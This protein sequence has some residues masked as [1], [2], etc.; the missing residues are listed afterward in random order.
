MPQDS[1]SFPN[2]L[3]FTLLYLPNSVSHDQIFAINHLLDLVKQ[4]RSLFSY[5]KPKEIFNRAMISTSRI[6][7]VFLCMLLISCQRK[8][9]DQGIAF[10]KSETIVIGN[11][12]L[13]P[14]LI[15]ELL[16]SVEYIKLETSS[17][18]LIKDI[19]DVIFAKN[20]FYIQNGRDNLLCFDNSGKFLFQVGGNGRGPG[21]Y[22]SCHQVVIKEEQNRIWIVDKQLMKILQYDLEG[23]FIESLPYDFFY[24]LYFPLNYDKHCFYL[25]TTS[26]SSRSF[27]SHMIIRTDDNFVLE[28]AYLPIDPQIIQINYSNSRIGYYYNG[29]L[30]I[31]PDFQNVIYGIGEDSIWQRYILDFGNEFITEAEVLKIA[32]K[33]DLDEMFIGLRESGK[34]Y[35]VAYLLE[36]DNYLYF[37]YSKNGD[38]VTNFYSKTSKLLYS[39]M[40]FEDDLGSGI[41]YDLPLGLAGDKFIFA[42]PAY[43]LYNRAIELPTDKSFVV[44][45]SLSEIQKDVDD[46]DN[47]VL[48][49]AKLKKR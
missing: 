31:R 38:V 33:G 32:S 30:H 27:H 24:N 47:P 41:H 17:K 28:E 3:R 46:N 19:R 20:R 23:K 11:D 34:V 43:E 16:D 45:P 26:N 42:L 8:P 36:S 49:L 48:A 7:F 9:D 44:G 13:H 5:E 29:G 12:I 40:G 37:I 21:E 4:P 35:T 14:R 1:P 6:L 39:Q 15:S 10:N 2:F 22:A 25:G 18:S